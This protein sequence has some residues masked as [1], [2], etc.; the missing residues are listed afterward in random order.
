MIAVERLCQINELLNKRSEFSNIE[1]LKDL[2]TETVRKKDI[3]NAMNNFFCSVGKYLGNKVAPVPNPLLSGDCEVNK[4][5][6]EFN[7][8]TITVKDI[9]AAF[10]KIKT[11]KSFGIDNISSFF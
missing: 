1:C 11:A 3:S 4:D 5:K 6:A 7:F 9:G 10:A 2:G 8:K